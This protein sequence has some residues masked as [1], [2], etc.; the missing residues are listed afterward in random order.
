[1]LNKKGILTGYTVVIE[2]EREEYHRDWQIS[3][4]GWC[5]LCEVSFEAI[6]FQLVNLQGYGN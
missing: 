4:Y 6:K 5:V 1:M 3:Q 2:K